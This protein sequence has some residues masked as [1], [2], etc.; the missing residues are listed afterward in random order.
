MKYN[1]GRI[2]SSLR[3]FGHNVTLGITEISIK[4]LSSQKHQSHHVYDIIAAGAGIIA[5]IFLKIIIVVVYKI[6][7]HH[8]SGYI[9]LMSAEE[10]YSGKQIILF[11]NYAT[12]Q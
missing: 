3:Y 10:Q 8:K 1:G 9:Q 11:C 7:V 4:E 2:I 6:K 5:I 12:M